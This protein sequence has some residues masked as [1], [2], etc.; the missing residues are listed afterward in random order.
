MYDPYEMWNLPKGGEEEVKT[1][2]GGFSG[3]E[4]EKEM[5]DYDTIIKQQYEASGVRMD[6]TEQILDN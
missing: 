4:I 6:G 2:E 1:Q 3:Q 5:I